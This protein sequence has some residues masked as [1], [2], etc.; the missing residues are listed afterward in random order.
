MLLIINS[1]IFL[2]FVFCI[3]YCLAK[4]KEWDKSIDKKEHRLY[5]LY[6]LAYLMLTKLHLDIRLLSKNQIYDSIKAIYIT[7]KPER[8]LMLYYCKR[9]STIIVVIF[10]FHLLSIFGSLHTYS[11]LQLID[12][13]YLV[14]PDYGRGNV[15]V[16]LEVFFHPAKDN[17]A[18]EKEPLSEKV[19]IKVTEREYEQD[20]LHAIFEE[21]EAFLKINVLGMNESLDDIYEK[22]NFCTTIPGTSIVV[23]WTPKDLSLIW[24]DGTVRNEGIAKEGILTSVT[25]VLTYLDEKKEYT[26]PLR[27]MPKQYSKEEALKNKLV[28]EVETASEKTAEEQL[29]ELPVTIDNYQL[30]WREQNK[31]QG[32]FLLGMGIIAAGLIWILGDKELEKQLKLRNKEMLID[33][34]EIINKFTLLVNA[35]MTAR[36]AWLKIA[37]DYSDKISQTQMAKRYAYEEMMT[38]VHELK[39][40]VAESMAYEQYGRRT[41]LIQ[42]IKFSSLI[43]QN[44]KKGNKGFTD[45]LRKEAKNAFEERKDT[46]RRLGEEAGTKLLVPMMLMLIIIFT[47][48][49]L[50]AFWSFHN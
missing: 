19:S 28:N 45:L 5:F 11:N 17:S 10:L 43:S 40:G 23:E 4:H 12:G 25:A 34:P 16:D 13:K 36:Q 8:M 27:I 22:L 30:S 26:I 24:T 38:T 31:N 50:P 3:I 47:M 39:I 29:L 49:L 37:E 42:Y 9:V 14:R 21:S 2:L 41:G 32:A 20:K 48:I 46:A 44:L 15:D 18:K 35:G 7:N 33:Y 1:V 6:P